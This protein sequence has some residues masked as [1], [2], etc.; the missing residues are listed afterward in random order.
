MKKNGHK[1]KI[2][3][4]VGAAFLI[5]AADLANDRVYITGSITHGWML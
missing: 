4:D 2:L 1:W 3:N 5:I